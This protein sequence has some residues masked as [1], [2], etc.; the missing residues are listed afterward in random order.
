[1]S[2][3]QSR[4]ELYD[5][6]KK[7]SKSEV[8]LKE[9]KRLGY[10]HGDG[11]EALSEALLKEHEEL[12]RELRE[13]FSKGQIYTN[14][15][16]AVKEVHKRRM[17]T[18]RKNRAERK[19]AR[20]EDLKKKAEVWK[21]KKSKDIFYLGA[22]FSSEL[23]KLESDTEKL[24]QYGLPILSSYM[25]LAEKME[26][27]LGELKFLSYARGVSKSG[28]YKRF[29]MPKKSGGER[30]IS[31]P[32]PRLKAVQYWL[33][34]NVLD[35]LPVHGC[36]HGFTK[37]RSIVSN[38][39]PHVGADVVVNMDLRDFFPTVNYARVLGMFK[40]L[41][42]APGI[43]TVMALLCTEPEIE[44]VEMD[45][46]T[47][48]VAV[49]QRHL[50][51]GAPTSPAITNWLCRRLD[52]RLHGIGA[53]HGF[54]FTRYAD[55]LTFSAKGES[56]KDL[57]KLLWQVKKVISE[58]GFILHPDKLRIM[59]SGQRHEVTGLVVN[60]K[61]SVARDEVRAF[62][63]VVHRLKTRGV[64]GVTFQGSGDRILARVVGYARFLWMVDQERFGE[65]L[66][67]VEA[68]A[69]SLGYEQVIRF[70]K[71]KAEPAV[72]PS[73]G[74]NIKEKKGF[75]RKILGFFGAN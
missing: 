71:A 6:I 49:S 72:K 46:Q 60:D 68:V 69:S 37:D 41:G 25:E 43:S 18:A 62:R 44:E 19:L 51:Q 5:E 66:R 58:E 54:A 23:G 16:E 27:S 65:T 73:Q 32:M 50:P 70:P 47:W 21:E 39:L 14:R 24:A 10:W 55:D 26:I 28:H 22:G 7:S 42:Y 63:A 30:L 8:I 52:S 36:C 9:M 12:S 59:R 74:K 31:A 4:Q 57:T 2:N 53:K 29:L 67:E 11:E 35:A 40:G 20:E 64:S 3:S 33:L 17:A 75:F 61:V 15:E 45:G 38:A 56:V 13:L 34:V 1:M 48:N